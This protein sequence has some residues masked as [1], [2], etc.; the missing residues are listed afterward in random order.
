L[1]IYSMLEYRPGGGDPPPPLEN[2]VVRVVLVVF[3]HP[4]L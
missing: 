2:L 4:P 3:L 1:F